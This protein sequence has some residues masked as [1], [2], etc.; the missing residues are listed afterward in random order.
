MSSFQTHFQLKIHGDVKEIKES[1]IT[2][3]VESHR[4]KIRNKQE[5]HLSIPDLQS[6]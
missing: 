6:K 3:S 1:F 5:M 2:D 4:N